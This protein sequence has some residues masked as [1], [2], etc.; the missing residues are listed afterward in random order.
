MG[1]GDCLAFCSVGRRPG[2]VKLTARLYLHLPPALLL[3]PP[4]AG[5]VR[6]RAGGGV[7]AGGQPELRQHA[8]PCHVSSH[9]RSPGRLP[10][11]HAGPAARGAGSGGSAGHGGTRCRRQR[12]RGCRRQRERKGHKRR[13]S[14][15]AGGARGAAA[16]HLRPD[17]AVVCGGTGGVRRRAEAAG[18]GQH[19]RRGG[20]RWRGACVCVVAAAACPVLPC[21]LVSRSPTCAPCCCPLPRHRPPHSPP[22][23]AP[24]IPATPWLPCIL[25]L[26]ALEAH[27]AARYPAWVGFCHNDLQYGNMLLFGSSTGGTASSAADA[28]TAAAAAAAAAGTAAAA[29]QEGGAAAGVGTA[30]AAADGGSPA[31]NGAA[32]EGDSPG[33]AAADADGAG[34]K[35]SDAD[36][37]SAAGPLSIKLIDY[38]YS[39][40]NDVSDSCERLHLRAGGGCAHSGGYAMS[41]PAL[42]LPRLDPCNVLAGGCRCPMIWPTTSASGP[43][44]TTQ[45]R[46]GVAGL[47]GGRPAAAAA[48][49]ALLPF[50]GG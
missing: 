23:P 50:A 48:A 9:R 35:A 31:A 11:P 12:D 14:G 24:F 2:G 40:L 34:G 10:R 38:E 1:V 28:A 41:P 32:G 18:S 5:G 49:A 33:E 25:Q 16:G 27:L 15:A 6:Q 20:R 4:S 29:A 22:R 45:V 26:A 47:P 43:T 7:P 44:I 46:A 13:R 21:W 8:G 39:T 19:S 42:L 3:L 30:A 37:G 36:G 17:T